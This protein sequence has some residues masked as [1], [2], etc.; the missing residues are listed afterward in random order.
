MRSIAVSTMTQAPRLAY[1]R[2]ELEPVDGISKRQVGRLCQTLD[3]EVE[4][5]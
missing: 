2:A 1:G 5:S 3:A 4:R